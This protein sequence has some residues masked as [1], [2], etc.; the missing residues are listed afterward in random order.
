MTDLSKLRAC[1][2]FLFDMDGTLY[3]GDEVYDGAQQLLPGRGGLHHPS[4]PPGLPL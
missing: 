2:L 1:E 4:A 3:L